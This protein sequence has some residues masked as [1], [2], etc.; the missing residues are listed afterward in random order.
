M[1]I[2][3]FTPD[4]F[5]VGIKQQAAWGT[6]ITDSVAFVNMLCDKPQIMADVKIRDDE[7]SRGARFRDVADL[8]RDEIGAMPKITLSC[9][10]ARKNDLALLL[11]MFFQSVTEAATTPYSKIFIA[12]AT[13]PDFSVNAGCFS[14]IIV[15]GPITS[16]SRKINDCI[17]T[18]LNL[19]V[20][21]GGLLSWTADIVGRGAVILNS[22][23][24]GTWT[25]SADSF[26]AFESMARA[27]YN[28]GAAAS[29][30]TGAFELELNR[31]VFDVGQS[32]GN[33]ATFGLGKFSGTLKGSLIYDT[34]TDALQAAFVAA[35]AGTINYAWGNATPGTVDG[36]FDITA[37][38]ALKKVEFNH[39]DKTMLDYEL[40][41]AGVSPATTQPI[42]ITMADA[43]DKTW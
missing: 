41:L 35:T 4:D 33:F 16:K 40:D 19:K 12:H 42:T 37:Y 2:S 13:Q 27:T 20:S 29:P 14:S 3:I 25:F 23:P 5:S 39:S 31:E 11:Y 15:K 36:D 38:G 32:G 18:K 10:R 34:N 30:V 43:V 22:N 8:N 24:S 6:A 1:A 17:C 28:F 26:Y 7:N 21:P 9:P